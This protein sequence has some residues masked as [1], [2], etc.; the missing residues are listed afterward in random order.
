MATP[1]V[2]LR[3]SDEQ[4]RLCKR[5]LPTLQAAEKLTLQ[6]RVAVQ[7]GG[8][9]GVFPKHL[10]RSFGAVYTFEPSQ[11]L[12]PILVANATEPN[13]LRYQAALG[14]HREMVGTSRV[15]RD[16]KPN[17]HEGIT[18]ISGPGPIPTL[19]LD[20]FKFP[21]C[22]LLQLDLEGWDLYALQGAVETIA[23]CRPVLMVEIN[24]NAAFVGLN[25]DEIR[26][27]VRS[28]GYRFV[29]R[30][31]SDEIYVPIERGES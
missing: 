7:A 19:R 5:D 20:D 21:V 4:L 6:R 18:H 14:F 30:L 15:R 24:K 10:A 28:L 1:R 8:N 25:E 3:G 13:I 12:F 2:G 29:S 11:E 16:G 17:N 23:R 27:Y 22:D 9:L 26:A 31:H